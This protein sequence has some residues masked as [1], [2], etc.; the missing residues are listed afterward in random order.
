MRLL[1]NTKKEIFNFYQKSKYELARDFGIFFSIFLSVVLIANYVN[2]IH[3]IIPNILAVIIC[4]LGT[5]ILYYTKNYKLVAY[6]TS[7]SLLILTSSIYFVITNTLHLITPLWGILNILFGFYIIGRRWG[8]FL[9]VSHFSFLLLYIFFRLKTNILHTPPIKNGDILV[10]LLEATIFSIGFWYI[11]LKYLTTN[12]HALD[13]EKKIRKQLLDKIEIISNQNDE[14]AIMLQEIHHRVKN[15]LQ[16][17]TSIL[18][19]QSQ[20]NQNN[21]DSF[22]EAIIRIESISLIHQIIYKQDFT[23]NFDLE[24]Y[25]KLLTNN[26]IS[27][28]N[29]KKKIKLNVSSKLTCIQ[30]SS[31]V[32]IAI[33]LNELLTNSFKHAFDNVSQPEINISI[34]NIEGNNY[35]LIYSDNGNWK[36]NSEDGFGTEM[37]NTVVEQLEGSFEIFK[38]KNGTEYNFY[39]KNIEA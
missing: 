9:L 12:K 1:P 36:Q 16:I 20:D 37:I 39:I 38:N 13:K 6:I 34:N 21:Q 14:K 15:N 2:S 17:I 29:F 7:F 8:T 10:F 5:I 27:N 23:T 4:V 28:Y 24:E 31:I 18:R 3:T 22:K 30:C 25:F 33:L 26:I 19:L 11:T 35:K 32:P